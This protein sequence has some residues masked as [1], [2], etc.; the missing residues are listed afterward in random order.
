MKTRGAYTFFLLLGFSQVFAQ[1]DSITIS[2]KLE[3]LLQHKVSVSFKDEKGK[4]IAV[5]AVA[6]KGQFSVRVPVQSEPVLAR[7]GT[8]ATQSLSR[9]MPEGNTVG[10]P[11]PQLE[12]FI[13]HSPLHISGNTKYPMTCAV[14]GDAENDGYSRYKNEVNRQEQRMWDIRTQHF[15]TE[16]T[17]VANRLMKEGMEISKTITGQQK[18]FIAKH[19][20]ELA[21]LFLLSRM[22]NLFTQ[23]D[24]ET[25]FT[26]LGD[27]YKQ[28]KIAQP[29]IKRMEAMAPTAAGR[30]AIVFNKQDKDGNWINLAD[31]KGQL[32]LLDFW[33]SW[34]GP[35]RAS[36]P[37][38]KELYAQYHSKGFEIIAIA[39]ETAKTLEQQR[40]LW[41]AAIE[42]DGIPW[43]HI[44][45][46]ETSAK[47][48]L[49]KEYRVTAFPTK[50]LLDKEGKI[51]LRIT[52]SATDDIDKALE[53]A[54]KNIK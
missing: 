44:L 40:A 9:T 11:A 35:C 51:L 48:D 31:Y 8:S 24:F 30:P 34:C 5:S 21:S 28:T 29:I 36:H 46:N 45:N 12:F 3:G 49:V 23:Q 2:G 26:A 52:A 22:Q 13:Y 54:L 4:A 50:I 1:A 14:T 19:P 47:Q 53:K 39:Q 42:K 20:N 37:H 43:K 33:G 38:L 16:D 41:L 27:K 15:F 25:A 18:K 32:V 7:L 10:S 6:D 17:A